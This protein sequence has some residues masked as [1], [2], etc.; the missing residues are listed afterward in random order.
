MSVNYH[1]MDGNVC[2][3]GTTGTN[4]TESTRTFEGGATRVLQVLAGER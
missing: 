4:G 2:V 1:T 3:R